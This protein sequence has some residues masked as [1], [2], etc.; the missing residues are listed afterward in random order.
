MTEKI[1]PSSDSLRN[2]AMFKSLKEFLL[3]LD[4]PTRFDLLQAL[5]VYRRLS[6]GQLSKLLRLSKPTVLH[7]LKKFEEFDFIQNTEIKAKHGPLPTKVYQFNE[8]IFN[9]L[10]RPLNYFI[11][12]QSAENPEEFLLSIK[13]KQLFF[14]MIANIFHKTQ[15]F[16]AEYEHEFKKFLHEMSREITRNHCSKTYM[17]QYRLSQYISK[18]SDGRCD[19]RE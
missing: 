18:K 1:F 10:T 12:L 17:V 3:I 6:L 11:N 9:E 4:S 16:Y 15:D 2:A 13:S 5:F 8:E 19:K 14:T 7:H